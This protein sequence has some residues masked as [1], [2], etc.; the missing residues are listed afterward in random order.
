[1]SRSFV[2]SLLA[3]GALLS[4]ACEPEDSKIPEDT[5]F[6][7]N[8]LDADGYSSDMD[9]DDNDPQ[10]H[11]GADEVCDEIDN[12]CDGEIDEEVAQLWYPDVDGD[13]FGDDTA[14][15]NSCDPPPGYVEQGGDCDD[16]DPLS[17]PGATEICDGADNDCDGEV[18]DS[19]DDIWYADAD[20]DGFGNPEF[21]VN[22]CDPGGAW[23]GNSDDCDDLSAQVYPDASE[24]CDG[25]DN[26]C[27]GEVDEDLSG[28]W[29]ADSDGD[30]YGDA[31]TSIDGCELGDGW[32]VDSTDC[33]DGDGA[34]HPGAAEYCNGHDDDC[35]GLVDDAD[36]DTSDQQT[37]Y[38]DGDG[39]GFGLDSSTAIACFAPSNYAAVGGDCNDGD[40]TI[41]PDGS[42]VCGGGDEDCDG[43]I[44]DDDPDATGWTTWY[45]DAD[46]DGHGAA[47]AS[48]EACAQPAG[49]AAAA[50]DC[51]DSNVA[52]SPAAT[53][54]CN[55]LDDDCD[56]T[57]DEA[58][59][60]DAST[61]FADADLDGYGDLASTTAACDQ[62]TG[63]LTDS[64]DCDD[65][66]DDIHPGATELCDGIDNDCDGSSD[67]DDAADA[68]TWYADVDGDGYGDPSTT[69]AACT[70][71]GGYQGDGTD[72]DDGDSAVNPGAVEICDGLDN[73]CDGVTDE[74]DAVD[75]SGWYS[76]VDGDGYGDPGSTTAACSQPSGY[77]GD[78]TDCNDG[79]A[80]IHPGGTEVCDGVDNDCDGTADESD[81]T[82]AASWYADDDGDGYGDNSDSTT[83][84]SQ[85]SGYVAA[86]SDCDDGDSA[87]H[88]AATESCNGVDD[89]C[90]GLVDDDDSGVAGVST[91]YL[92]GDLDGYGSASVTTTA[93]S[94]PAGYLADDSDCD[95]ADWAVYPGATELC[96]GV[97][98][99]CDSLVDDDDLDLTEWY[100]WYLDADG[101]G[102]GDASD[103]VTACA[104]PTGYVDNA[105]D[106]DDDDAGIVDCS[107]G[108][109]VVDTGEEEDPDPGFTYIW[110]DSACRW[111]FSGI[112]QLYCNGGCTWAGSSDCDQSDADIFCQLLMDNPSSTATSWTSTTALALPGF[113]CPGGGTVL[114]TDRGV[115]VT[116][117]YQDSSILATHGPGNVI[118]YPVCTD[119]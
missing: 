92:D 111:D 87:V 57:V 113:S 1:M 31:A 2:T 61:W 51:D 16:A 104:A 23:V 105:D 37:W 82:D 72:C 36:P 77:V 59:A 29:H 20:G 52:I 115:G 24:L 26:D 76:D 25:L 86:D 19:P 10:V 112:P 90:D 9:C 34:V 55:G 114:S 39:D 97:D 67:E 6:V 107:C 8:D 4:V 56:G 65:H 44:D 66:D 89:D 63:F 13:G 50:L 68:S 94:Q 64:S 40:S 93:C 85:P 116:V 62:P 32:V 81:V 117:Y 74:P 42:E 118:A 102:Y 95:D 69:S 101:D 27:D 18:D 22:S 49:Y 11:P 78:G 38:L 88:P 43:L 91:W 119:P 21:W 73:D 46:G 60:L 47:H 15:L 45:L 108:D 70:Q 3:L 98:N 109:G 48:V 83:A 103:T 33:D 35:D 30:G 71:P 28:I 5:A 14:T 17:W 84:C 100:T 54:L 80:S 41:N 106:C 58:D 7:Q 12:D 75:A 99:D 79:D 110:L 53:E 96:D